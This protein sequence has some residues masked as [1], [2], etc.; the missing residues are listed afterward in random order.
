MRKVL[1]ALAVIGVAL[2]ACSVP[3][4][5]EEEIRDLPCVAGLDT[6]VE[7]GVVHVYFRPCV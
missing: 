4:F 2:A 6:I 1:V 3:T 5:P 7:N